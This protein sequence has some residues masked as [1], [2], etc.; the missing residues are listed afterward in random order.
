MNIAEEYYLPRN[1]ID[2]D[3]VE[4]EEEAG[5]ALMAV[6]PDYLDYD[7]EDEDTRFNH[8]YGLWGNK[9]QG[10]PYHMYLLSIAC[11]I[12]ARLGYKAFVYGDITRGQCRKAVEMANEY[13]DMPIDIPDRCDM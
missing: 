7:W 6:L 10:E 2:G 11:L 12:E 9:T 4:T 1:L 3:G 13:L 5:D 8:C